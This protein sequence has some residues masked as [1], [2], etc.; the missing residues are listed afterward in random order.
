MYLISTAKYC[1]SPAQVRV[2]RAGLLNPALEGFLDIF[3]TL[4]LPKY[5]IAQN[6]WHILFWP[7]PKHMW[8]LRLWSFW[9]LDFIPKFYSFGT[10]KFKKLVASLGMWHLNRYINSFHVSKCTALFCRS[11]GEA[12]MWYWHLNCAQGLKAEQVLPGSALSQAE[13][14]LPE[15]VPPVQVEWALPRDNWLVQL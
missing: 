9:K 10:W 11:A 4:G 7:W 1:T 15:Q 2:F 13:G 3:K 5:L 6:Y 8:L 14:A 12:Y